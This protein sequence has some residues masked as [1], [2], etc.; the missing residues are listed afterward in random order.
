MEKKDFKKFCND[1][2]PYLKAVKGV[3]CE[4]GLGSK[5]SFHVDNESIGISYFDDNGL[6]YSMT[7]SII[8][9]DYSNKNAA[10]DGN[11]EAAKQ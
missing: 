11:P 10:P 2:M 7:E 5:T 3:I 6:H 9:R 1:V 4:Y 8:F